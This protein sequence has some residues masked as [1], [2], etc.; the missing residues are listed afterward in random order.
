MDSFESDISN[1]RIATQLRS[2]LREKTTTTLYS[3]H[4]DFIYCNFTP[5]LILIILYNNAMSPNQW[6]QKF[7]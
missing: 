7:I 5:D 6:I 2:I 3:D 4:V 1:K